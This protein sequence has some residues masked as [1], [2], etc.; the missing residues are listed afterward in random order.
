MALGPKNRLEY[1]GGHIMVAG[2]TVTH[3]YIIHIHV[4]VHV[5]VHVLYC[6]V[7]YMYT[8]EPLLKDTLQQRTSMLQ[9]TLTRVPNIM[10]WLFSIPEERTPH[11]KGHKILSHWCP[12]NRGSTV[13]CN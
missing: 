6:T 3:T 1:R 8:V 7:L 9:R 4:H 11:C 13:I 5:N 12:L 10:L 2:S